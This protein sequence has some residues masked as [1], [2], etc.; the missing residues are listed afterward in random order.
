[1]EYEISEIKS[2]QYTVTINL[3]NILSPDDLNQLKSNL[4][5]LVKKDRF[6]KKGRDGLPIINITK[7]NE[8]ELSYTSE[9]IFPQRCDSEKEKVLLV[10][11][12]PATHSIKYGMFFFSKSNLSRHNIWKKLHKKELITMVNYSNSPNLS[13]LEIR[14]KEAKERIEMISKGETSQNYLVGLTT[15][16]SFPTPV[17]DKYKFSNVSGVLKLFKPIIDS[18]NIMESKRILGYSFTNDATLVFVQ[19]DSYDTFKKYISSLK[20]PKFKRLI[21]WPVVSRRPKK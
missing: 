21:Y 11:G 6:I 5:K 13:K 10:F 3:E 7:I 20:N 18:T 8:N 2:G 4:K 17:I 12:N 9:T 1:M 14:T 16:Y 15:F 19:K